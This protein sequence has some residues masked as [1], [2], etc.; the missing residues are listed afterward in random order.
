MTWTEVDIWQL[1]VQGPISPYKFLV[2]CL[3]VRVKS[4]TNKLIEKSRTLGT[5]M[6]F[7]CYLFL[8][9]ANTHINFDLFRW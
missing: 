3:S 2:P 6:V 4:Q 9:E 8:K 5:K 1:D 7:V